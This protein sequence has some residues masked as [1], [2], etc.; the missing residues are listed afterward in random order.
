KRL[1]AFPREQLE[2]AWELYGRL[3][4]LC[5][6]TSNGCPFRCSYCASSFLDPE[7][8]QREPQLVAREISFWTER[9]Q[10]TDV[11]FYDDAL[12]LNFE[13]HLKKILQ[14]IPDWQRRQLRFHAPNG[15]NIRLLNREVAFALKE[16]GFRTIRLS[17]ESEQPGRVASSHKVSFA[18]FERAMMWLREAGFTRE[19]I[20]VYIMVG[21][22]GQLP[23]Q[24]A[25]TIH[26]L[27]EYPCRIKLAEYSPVPSTAT[28]QL[29]QKLHPGFSLQEPLLHNNSIFP[30]WHFPGKWDIIQEL[31]ELVNSPAP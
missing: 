11:A 18:D 6:R 21:W 2:P 5:V 3:S 27:K 10:V 15:L 23:S 25:R 13:R 24:V 30:A 7:L 17:L 31:K 16:A 8:Y 29:C 4:Y 12:L 9:F 22:P 28:F 20:G 26:L 1:Q 14:L 19:E